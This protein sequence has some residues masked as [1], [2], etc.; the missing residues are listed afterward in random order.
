MVGIVHSI[1]SVRTIWDFHSVRRPEKVVRPR[2][3]VHN[4][5]VPGEIYPNHRHRAR[6]LHEYNPRPYTVDD[7]I[8][9][10]C[11]DCFLDS[12]RFS[13]IPENATET[14]IR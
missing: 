1:N 4:L 13:D 8:V 6:E 11:Q 3:D 14:L 5:N 2:Y 10:Q 7:Y 9:S 12:Y